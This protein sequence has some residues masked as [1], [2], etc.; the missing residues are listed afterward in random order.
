MSPMNPLS[1]RGVH[2]QRHWLRLSL[3]LAVAMVTSEY[4]S[5]PV[6]ACGQEPLG[7]QPAVA[8]TPVGQPPDAAAEKLEGQEKPPGASVKPPG[9][10][11][12]PDGKGKDDKAKEEGPKNVQ[13]KTEP[14]VPPNPDELKVR[15]DADGMVQFQFRNQPWPDLLNWLADVSHVSLDWQELPGDYLNIATQRPYTL[16]EAR[17]AINRHL[18]LRGFTML[19]SERD[20]SVVKVASI[21]PAMVPRVQPSELADQPPHRFVRTSFELSI[22]VAANVHEEFK[23]MLSPNGKI[24]PLAATNRLEMM[25]AAA[26]LL[27]V[28]RVIDDEQ[29]TKALD[30]LAREF[31]LKHARAM[32]VKDQLELFLGLKKPQSSGSSR[33]GGDMM[34]MVQQQMQQMQQQMQQ[35]QPSQNKKQPTKEEIYL[36]ANERNNSVIVSAPQ[37]KMAIVA[38]FIA[39]MDVPNDQ[40]KDFERVGIRTKVFRLVSLAPAELVKSLIAMDVLEPS[41]RLQVDEANNAII[42]YASIADQYVIQKLIERLDGSQRN[43][44]VIQLRRLEAE[45]VAGTLKFLMGAEDENKEDNNRNRYSYFDFY[46]SSRSQ[47]QKKTDKMRIGANVQDNQLL[48][49]ANEIEMKEVQSLLVKMGELPPPGGRASTLRVIDASKQPATYEYLMKLKEQWEKISPNSLV[50][51]D[52][53]AF[54]LPEENNPKDKPKDKEK[55]KNDLKAKAKPEEVTQG[56]VSE[57]S[58]SKLTSLVTEQPPVGA[59]DSGTR[60]LAPQRLAAEG[61]LTGDVVSKDSENTKAQESTNSSRRSV[62][63][64]ETSSSIPPKILIQVDESGKLILQSTDAAALDRLEEM[65]MI[66]KPPQRPYDVFKIKYARATW[67]KLN[68]DDYFKKEKKQ[69]VNNRDRY[70]AYIFD[71]PLNEKKEEGRQ[72]GKKAEIRFIADNDTNSIVVIGADDLDRRTIKELIDLWDVEE[73]VS[74]KDVRYTKLVRIKHSK[75]EAIVETIKEAYKDLLSSNDS[76]FQQRNQGGGGGGGRGNQENKRNA[77]EETVQ[78][79]GG[80]NSNFKGELS[81]G[82]DKI[83]NS[84]L[85][86]ARGEPLLELVCEMI[87]TLDV[88]AQPQGNVEVFKLTP[89]MAN[90]KLGDAVR[91]LLGQQ[92][93]RAN[94][95][96]GNSN[97]NNGKPNRNQ[98]KNNGQ[99]DFGGN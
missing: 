29:S 66:N 24:T 83:T 9:D 59:Q 86:S 92:I 88:A 70:Y 95:A 56:K 54:K 90:S 91:S 89:G 67:V 77:P 57:E 82:A 6:S 11:K 28:H 2:D 74:G 34:E 64:T 53:E 37:N 5:T 68:L 30:D 36:V 43:A 19:E 33:G 79:D 94:N 63:A 42:A 85:V 78:A 84:I 87:D 38:A 27:D 7:E 39:R 45:A 3:S 17:D 26:N 76:A 14:P 44:S 12:K 4:I 15:P 72:L 96:N 98:G 10:D 58:D 93:E 16:A 81:L 31:P 49:W 35:G 20:I 65:M 40:A 62:S 97:G 22:L 61:S 71:I 51:P 41:T 46:G 32:F 18:L 8:A 48:I 47:T 99:P 13:R 60:E 80:L 73:P 1:K 25:D 69:D 75:A 21:S 23:S 55:N 50:L 52:E